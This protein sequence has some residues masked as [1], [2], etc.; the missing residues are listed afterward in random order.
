MCVLS[1]SVMLWRC[2]ALADACCGPIMWS[3]VPAV[4]LTRAGEGTRRPPLVNV[5]GTDWP[6]E[7]RQRAPS[8]GKRWVS[9]RSW[10]L[11]WSCADP[12]WRLRSIWW[13]Q[14]YNV[15]WNSW[16]VY[17]KIILDVPLRMLKHLG[18]VGHR[19]VEVLRSKSELCEWRQGMT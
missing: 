4:L 18:P 3:G 14:F 7:V 17:C 12:S 2:C 5:G 16:F 11:T 10:S 1:W 13:W 6:G 8:G 19:R 9:T 15:W